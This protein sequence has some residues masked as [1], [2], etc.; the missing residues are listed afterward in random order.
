MGTTSLQL[1]TDYNAGVWNEL[2]NTK[3]YTKLYNDMLKP[4]K[5]SD[6]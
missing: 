5:P 6:N 3:Y 2:V 1:M 4:L